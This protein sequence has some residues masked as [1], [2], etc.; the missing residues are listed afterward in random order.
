MPDEW[1]HG[2]QDT[3]ARDKKPFFLSSEYDFKNF[4]VKNKKNEET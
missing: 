2:V 1:T 4:L 3:D